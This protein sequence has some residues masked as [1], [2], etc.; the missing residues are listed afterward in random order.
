MASPF[1]RRKI[2]LGFYRLD[3]SKD[4]LVMLEDF[5]I[6]GRQV[7]EQLKLRP[8]SAEYEK[9]VRSFAGLWNAFGKAAD[10]DGD[11]KISLE[12]FLETHSA[13]QK[14]PNARE[15]VEAANAMIFDALDLN[16]DGK[17]DEHEYLTVLL[18][19]GSSAEQSRQ[20]FQR[21]DHNNNGFLSRAE[22]ATA[23][24]EYWNSEDP[25]AVGNWFYG[26]Y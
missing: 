11:G 8:G 21:L 9:T 19:M 24:Y 3:L 6:Y 10:T 14:Q 18:P 25:A 17:I 13:L 7:A 2:A 15:M 22:F 12:D 1:L 5:E 20:A 16:G 23:L 26:S 4:G